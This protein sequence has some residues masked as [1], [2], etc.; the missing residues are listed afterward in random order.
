MMQEG[1]HSVIARMTSLWDLGRKEFYVTLTSSS[2]SDI[3]KDNHPA[4]FQVQLN[5]NIILDP[6]EGWEVALADIHYVHDFANIGQDTFLKMRHRRQIFTLTLPQWYCEKLEDLVSFLTV[7][8]NEFLKQLY[9]GKKNEIKEVVSYLFS[10]NNQPLSLFRGS[11]VVKEEKGDNRELVFPDESNLSHREFSW[12][13]DPP[14]IEMTL[15]SLDR[16]RIVCTDPDFDIAFS[17]HLLDILGLN[18]EQDLTLKSFNARSLFWE[19]IDEAV[20][21]QEVQGAPREKKNDEDASSD[22]PDDDKEEDQGREK[23]SAGDAGSFSKKL[24]EKLTGEHRLGGGNPAEPN[25]FMQIVGDVVREHVDDLVKTVGEKN[26]KPV[27]EKVVHAIPEKSPVPQTN[28]KDTVPEK[29]EPNSLGRFF[30]K[31]TYHPHLRRKF[32]PNSA[33]MGSESMADFELKILQCLPMSKPQLLKRFL[34]RFPKDFEVF[35]KY[36]NSLKSLADE[37]PAGSEAEQFIDAFEYRKFIVDCENSAPDVKEEDKS[38]QAGGGFSKYHGFL[39]GA[40]LIK[41]ILFGSLSNNLLVGGRPGRI[42][43]FEIL[44]VYTDLIKPDPFNDMMSRILISFQNQG[45]N[46]ERVEFTPNPRQ[47][48]LLDKC[49][50][51]HMKIL[52]GG[53]RGERVPFQ[54]GPSNI[55]LHFRRVAG[56]RRRRRYHPY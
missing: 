46:G 6:N 26:K 49:N 1:H 22:N 23:R 31:C 41:K 2:N 51:S 7:L 47:Y 21:E 38:F 30:E 40:F 35:K 3:F 28:E 16:V 29:E 18:D 56:R 5:H 33:L 39:F 42:N 52:I 54:R 19:I 20:Q 55:T 14:K 48:K 34:A 17:D 36:G 53:D 12:I 32:Q 37:W 25:V 43:P 11:E 15:D 10:Q 27:A 50:I 24:L 8:V 4:E 44:F 13:T 9:E 45:L